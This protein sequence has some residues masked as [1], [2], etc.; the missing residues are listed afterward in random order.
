MW[1]V[2]VRGFLAD[3][4]N[5]WETVGSRIGGCGIW[6]SGVEALDDASPSAS[7]SIVASDL[8][9][10]LLCI[11][12]SDERLSEAWKTDGVGRRRFAGGSDGTAGLGAGDI[13][14]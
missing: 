4:L 7:S 12:S 9:V 3:V 14:V 1:E 2:L 11:S 13:C 5:V 10:T 6:T 8:S